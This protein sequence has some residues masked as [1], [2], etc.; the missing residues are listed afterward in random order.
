M[1]KINLGA[2][3]ALYPMPTVIVGTETDEGKP[4]FIAIAHVGILDHNTVSVSMGKGH[5]SNQWIRKNRTLSIN[6]P[7]TAM[8]EDT[9]FVG[10]IS[11]KDTDKS[12][13]FSVFYGELRGAPLI[14]DAPIGM[15]CEVI[16]VYDR[17][18][19]DVFVCRV[20]GT[21][22]NEEV[23]LEDG[24]IDYKAADP[25]FYEM[26]QFHYWS[27]GDKVERAYQ[28][29]RSKERLAREAAEHG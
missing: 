11:G 29:K 20:T 3:N 9:D 19:F 24:K 2:K 27:L 14:T 16:D 23:L 6:L 26:Q 28:V 22:A 5:Y 7:S 4:T 15:E 17:P 1:N 13:V 25:I 10:T 12:G 21:Y 18:E 8:A